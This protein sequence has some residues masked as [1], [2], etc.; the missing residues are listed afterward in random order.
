MGL[1]ARLKAFFRRRSSKTPQAKTLPEKTKPVSEIKR[2]AG[3]IKPVQIN[4]DVSVG[5]EVKPVSAC[6]PKV[7]EEKPPLITPLKIEPE[8]K[9][10]IQILYDEYERLSKEKDS[11]RQEMVELDKKLSAGELKPAERDRLFREKMVKVVGIAQRILEIR[12]RCAELG[13]PIE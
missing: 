10:E 5:E 4:K 1:I 8:A 7:L 12:A 2:E 3:T 9:S 6:E 13:K 11:V